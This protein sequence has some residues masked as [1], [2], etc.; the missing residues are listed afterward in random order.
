MKQNK[1]NYMKVLGI[2][3]GI[4]SGKSLITNFLESKFNAFIISADIVGHEIILKGNP[5]YKK[6]VDYFGTHILD[7]NEE[8]N[9]RIL[10]DIVFK[11]SGSIRKLNSITHP[12]ILKEI[13]R[14]I[15]II[16][17]EN[18]FSF[19]TLEAALVVGEDWINLVD[20]IWLI[21]CPTD[22]RVERLIKS[23]NLSKEKINNI[24]LNQEN[25]NELKKYA[26]V[27]IDNSQ[28]LNT[29]LEQVRI[30]TLKFLEAN[31][32]EE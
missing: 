30:E 5:A 10:G 28:D 2:I 12:L 31:N 27:I 32:N 20:N 23:R 18:K 8:I 15:K 17:L 25:D 24:L 7:E 26:D 22:I 14:R 4:G 3:G 6:I 19:I 29:T 11:N 1:N 13:E 9:R 16:K 21:S